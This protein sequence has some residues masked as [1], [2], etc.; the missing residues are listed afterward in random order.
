MQL[1]RVGASSH[2]SSLSTHLDPFEVGLRKAAALQTRD[3]EPAVKDNPSELKTDASNVHAADALPPL[4]AIRE[5]CS[6]CCNGSA[7]EVSILCC[8]V[9]PA[10]GLSLRQEANTGN[11]G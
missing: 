3:K 6:S 8:E 7:Y 11:P 9:V 2:A 4:K 1:R 5:H 10:V